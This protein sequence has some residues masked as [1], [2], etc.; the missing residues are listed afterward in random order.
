MAKLKPSD[1]LTTATDAIGD[2]MAATRAQWLRSSGQKRNELKEAYNKLKK[3]LQKLMFRDLKQIDKD[4][5]I[6]KAI[7]DLQSQ[8]ELILKAR[9]EMTTVTKTVDRAKK[10]IGYVDKILGVVKDVGLV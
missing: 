9:R 2:A 10:I 8:S 5:R 1:Y 7:A 4:P 3:C 6:K